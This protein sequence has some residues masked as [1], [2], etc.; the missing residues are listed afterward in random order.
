MMENIENNTDF[1]KEGFQ[2]L[3]ILCQY[4]QD[5]QVL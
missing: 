4:C 5:D 2:N 1:I 3:M